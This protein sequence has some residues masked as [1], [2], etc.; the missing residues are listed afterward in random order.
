M[1]HVVDLLINVDIM[2]RNLRAVLFLIIGLPLTSFLCR[3]ED[4]TGQEFRGRVA[5]LGMCGNITLS[6]IDG[7]LDTSRY[8]TAWKDPNTGITHPNAFR[9]ENPCTVGFPADIKVGDVFRFTV[10]E[11]S[12]ADRNCMMCM[13]YYPTPDVGVSIRYLGPAN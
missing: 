4:M 2:D 10:T 8:R 3:K 12:A 1:T 6:L 11:S 13:A 7:N 9:L 5:V